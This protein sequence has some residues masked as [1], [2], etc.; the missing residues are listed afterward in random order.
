LRQRH[1]DQK[2]FRDEAVAKLK[3][4]H[5][6]LQNRLDVMYEDRLDGRIDIPMFERKSA[7]Y[8]DRQTR[9]LTEIDRYA[10]ADGNYMDVG[11]HLLELT[12]NMHR[13]FEMQ[14]A[15]EKRR[16]LDFVVSN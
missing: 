7:E 8:R 12:R 6:R 5:L 14:P 1:S 3:L 2:R 13:L 16:L 11:I 4:E 10:I 9:I 15:A